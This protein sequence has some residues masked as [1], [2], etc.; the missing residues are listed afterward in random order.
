MVK[1][2]PALTNLHFTPASASLS[3]ISFLFVVIQ[4]FMDARYLII[5]SSILTRCSQTLH[6]QPTYR[7]FQLLARQID[8]MPKPVGDLY[9]LFESCSFLLIKSACELVKV[10]HATYAGLNDD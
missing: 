4:Q 1:L 6:V 2:L 8:V 7:C 5:V 3:S 10:M 9:P